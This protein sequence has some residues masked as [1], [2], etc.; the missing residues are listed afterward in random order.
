MI[1]LVL[2]NDIDRV[3]THTEMDNNFSNLKT[4]IE[5]SV[6]IN[7]GLV[8]ASGTYTYGSLVRYQGIAYV[9]VVESTA[10]PPTDTDSWQPVGKG[11]YS[12]PELTDVALTNP[13]NSDFLSYDTTNNKW[14]NKKVKLSFRANFSGILEKTVSNV[15]YYPVNDITIKGVSVTLGMAPNVTNTVVVNKSSSPV[16]IIPI[17]AGIDRIDFIPMTLTLNTTEFLTVNCNLTTGKDLSL[18]F[19]YE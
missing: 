9:C 19:T 3:L 2:R 1:N 17:A 11:T 7:K 5:K 16:L 6:N 12:I 10:T 14:V 15:K 18:T 8:W 4:A 13:S